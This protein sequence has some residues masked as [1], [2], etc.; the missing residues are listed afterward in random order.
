M[1][2]GFRFNNFEISV[3][4]VWI[5][6][7]FLP[8]CCWNTTTLSLICSK[9]G[10]S[11]H[12]DRM[13]LSMERVSYVRVLVEVDAAEPFVRE[14]KVLVEGVEWTQP[15]EY[16]FEPKYCKTCGKFG[17]GE[18]SCPSTETWEQKRVAYLEK[19][20]EKNRKNEGSS[21]GKIKGEKGV[22]VVGTASEEGFEGK[23][24]FDVLRDEGF[25]EGVNLSGSGS[26]SNFWEDSGA[27][28]V[29]AFSAIFL[30][31]LTRKNSASAPISTSFNAVPVVD[32]PPVAGKV[33]AA[34]PAPV[35]SASKKVAVHLK[36]NSPTV[37]NVMAADFSFIGAG[38]MM[39]FDHQGV[40]NKC[41]SC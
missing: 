12:S 18:L 4:P 2:L 35:F 15:V 9:I 24:R 7:K 1:P 27:A 10:R 14:I 34:A 19:E 30:S 40:N 23:G 31:S 13:T 3:M 8:M 16:E 32:V 39:I 5:K 37:S 36:A 28:H 26:P 21:K 20:D 38:A 6:L 22:E 29:E 41:I 11:I 25:E 17:H 33:G